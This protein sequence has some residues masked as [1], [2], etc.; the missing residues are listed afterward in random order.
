MHNFSFNCLT[1]Y[2]EQY[3]LYLN[4]SKWVKIS[5]IRNNGSINFNYTLGNKPLLFA[6]DLSVTLDS[7]LR[8][9]GKISKIT[10]KSK[11]SLAFILQLS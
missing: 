10:S 3:I 11:Q 2:Y 8:F 7:K 1:E 6:K 5:L 9:H 4:V